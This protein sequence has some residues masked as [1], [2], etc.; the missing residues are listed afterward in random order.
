MSFQVGDAVKAKKTF[1]T[2]SGLFPVTVHVGTKG[3]VVRV[4]VIADI[5]TVEFGSGTT[6]YQSIPAMAENWEYAPSEVKATLTPALANWYKQVEPY[7]GKRD[8]Q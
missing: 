2:S 1:S 4:D 5:Y 8:N 3:K 7:V 6:V